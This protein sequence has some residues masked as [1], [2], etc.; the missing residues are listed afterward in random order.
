MFHSFKEFF[1]IVP[2]QSGSCGFVDFFLDQP[3]EVD[4][5]PVSKQGH[6]PDLFG[7]GQIPIHPVPSTPKKSILKGFCQD[8]C[9]FPITAN[10]KKKP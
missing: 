1:R 10:V 8:V 7:G 6:L 4:E 9:V 2:Y 5:L 3:F